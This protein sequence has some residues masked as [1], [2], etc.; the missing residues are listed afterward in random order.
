MLEVV[1]LP[2]SQRREC[3]AGAYAVGAVATSARLRPL[4]ACEVDRTGLLPPRQQ[5]A[6]QFFGVNGKVRFGQQVI[7]FDC[8]AV[9]TPLPSDFGQREV[10]PVYRRRQ[11]NRF[12]ETRLRRGKIAPRFFV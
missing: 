2:A 7:L 11:T 3:R 5:G 9:V 8:N 12:F 1:R 4:D 6:L 10:S